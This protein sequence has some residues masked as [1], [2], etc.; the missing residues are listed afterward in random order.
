MRKKLRPKFWSHG[1]NLGSLG[2]LSRKAFL[3]IFSNV[4]FPGPWGPNKA[5]MISISPSH[6]KSLDQ[7]PTWCGVGGARPL[8]QSL[9]KPM[10][11]HNKKGSRLLAHA[12]SSKQHTHNPTTVR[13]FFLKPHCSC[14]VY[15]KKRERIKREALTV[16]D[17]CVDSRTV[18]ILAGQLQKQVRTGPRNGA[19]LNDRAAF[20]HSAI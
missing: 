20:F 13:S 18:W 4:V 8:T 6:A 17:V 12:N 5:A 7:I 11:S 16:C 10:L 19:S 2:P 1:T 14:C 9:S 3:K 15:V